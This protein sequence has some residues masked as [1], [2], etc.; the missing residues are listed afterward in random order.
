MN[1]R[2][3]E[4]QE[5]VEVDSLGR[6]LQSYGE[7]LKEDQDFGFSSPVHVPVPSK[8]RYIA[9]EFKDGYRVLCS[10]VKP[11]KNTTI[12][13]EYGSVNGS[14]RFKDFRV[15]GTG[16]IWSKQGVKFCYAYGEIV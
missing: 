14:T 3:Q 1:K 16:K 7:W 9:K 8:K 11:G 15:S 5:T 12:S 13:V 2:Y 6:P 10:R 4:Y